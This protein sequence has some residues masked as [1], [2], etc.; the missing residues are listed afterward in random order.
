MKLQVDLHTREENESYE[1][2]FDPVLAVISSILVN[3]SIDWNGLNMQ[4]EIYLGGK[5]VLF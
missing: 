1:G 3:A 5:L 4:L 2:G